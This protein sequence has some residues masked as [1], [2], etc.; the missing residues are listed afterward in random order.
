MGTPNGLSVY[1]KSLNSFVF[2]K[3]NN[4]VLGRN[5]LNPFVY[6]ILDKSQI[7]DIS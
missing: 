3:Q 5:W 7:T 1:N 4:R 6:A 2:L